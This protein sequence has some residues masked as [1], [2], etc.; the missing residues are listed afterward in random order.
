MGLAQ[1]LG[2]HQSLF[3][4]NYCKSYL[5]LLFVSYLTSNLQ[6]ALDSVSQNHMHLILQWVDRVACN[7]MPSS[8][9]PAFAAP[10]K[11]LLQSIL[12]LFL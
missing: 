1:N 8:R 11:I 10:G 12:R 2:V 9:A 6:L 5:F 4:A 7:Q 3:S